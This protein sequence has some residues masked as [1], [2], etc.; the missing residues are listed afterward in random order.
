[1]RKY[2]REKQSTRVTGLKINMEL[3]DYKCY[4]IASAI[5]LGN[6]SREAPTVV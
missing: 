3:P 6:H 5:F 4:I 2:I 1:M